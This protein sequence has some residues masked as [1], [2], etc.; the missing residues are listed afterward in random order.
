MGWFDA[1]CS[2]HCPSSFKGR[3]PQRVCHRDSQGG[4][5]GG[6]DAESKSMDHSNYHRHNPLRTQWVHFYHRGFSLIVHPDVHIN[7][8][9]IALRH[10]TD[11]INGYGLLKR[12]EFPRRG[13]LSGHL[14]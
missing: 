6:Y 13:S 3:T 1:V 14:G 8:Y 4:R 12:A 9:G 7:K 10:M 11:W 5:Q 2:L